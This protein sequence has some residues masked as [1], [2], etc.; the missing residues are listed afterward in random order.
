[1]KRLARSLLSLLLVFCLSAAAFPTP[2]EAG[3]YADAPYFSG[4]CGDNLTWVLDDDG[5][6]TISGTG[7]MTDY[8]NISSMPWYD[9]REDIKSVIIGDGVTSVGNYA[10]PHHYSLT[11]VTIPDSVT[12]IGS[13]AFFNCSGL[14]AVDIPNSVTSI[15][16]SAF[17]YCPFTSIV[18][19]ESVTSMGSGVFSN[20]NNL[21]F[22]TIEDG[23][24]S[25]GEG[26]FKYCSKLSSITIPGS[27]T[28]IGDYAF[29]NCSSLTEVVFEGNA[30]SIDDSAFDD[31]T[32]TCHYPAD[33]DTWTAA[34]R[35]NYGGTLTWV[36]PG[37]YTVQGECGDDVIWTLDSDGPLTISGTG[38]MWSA[39]NFTGDFNAYRN[40]I[41]TV[42]IE[43][44]VTSIGTYAFSYCANL[45][46]V[47]IPDS[48]TSI[49][50]YAFDGCASL[51]SIDIPESVT[52]IGDSVFCDCTSLSSVSIPDSITNPGFRTFMNCTNLTSVT[53]PSSTTGI[54]EFA[55]F[56]TGLTSISIPE[57][58]TQIASGAFADCRQLS[59]IEL[60][61]S[62]TTIESSALSSCSSL[63][64]VDFPPNLTT[65]EYDLLSSSGITSITIPEKV[66]S[67]GTY[68]FAN[69]LALKE[70]KFR[71]NAPSIAEDAFYISTATCYYPADDESWTEDVRQ[72][73]G[74]TLTWETTESPD[75]IVASGECGD[76]VIWTL[77]SNG[78]LTVSGTGEMTNFTESSSAPWYDYRADIKTIIMEDGATSIGDYAFYECANLTS[79]TIPDSVTAIGNSAFKYCKTLSSVT[80]PDKIDTLENSAFAYTGLTSI[81]IPDGI[82]SIGA[83]FI[84]CKS[85]SSI[86]IPAS[87]THISGG[88]FDGCSSLTSIELPPNLTTIEDGLFNYSGITSI[89]IPEKVTSIDASAFY[90][91]QGL[92][93]IVIPESVTSIGQTAF[94][95]CKNLKTIEFTGNPPAINAYA[96][97][98]TTATCY[99][100]S[101]NASWTD[102]VKQ[103][104]G[105]TLTWKTAACPHSFT[106]AVGSLCSAATCTAPALHWVK[107]DLCG[108]DSDTLTVSVGGTADHSFTNKP[109]AE[110][111]EPATCF[112]PASYYV[113]CDNCT[114]V[115][116][117]V[118]VRSGEPNPH[119]FTTKAGTLISAAT[120]TEPALHRVQCDN[121]ETNST[122]ET[123]TV[124]EALGH[125]YTTKASAQLHTAG[126]CTAPALYY[127]Q[128]DR[129][130]SVSDTLT[131]A[132]GEPAGHSFVDYICTVCGTEDTTV[133][134]SGYCG[135]SSNYYSV[136]W[137][138]YTSGKLIISGSG[139]T[140][141]YEYDNTHYIPLVPWNAH[142]DKITSVVVKDGVTSVGDE[143]FSCLENLKSA[144]IAGSVRYL[145]I[146]AFNR[147]SQLTEVTLREGVQTLG[148]FLFQSCDALKTI[149]LP[150][151]LTKV[152]TAFAHCAGLES[153]AVA[154]GSASFSSVDGVLFDKAQTC[155]YRYP[156]AR[157]GSSYQVPDTVTRIGQYAFLE[158]AGLKSVGLPAG[159]SYIG[160][161]AF[162]SSGLTGISI[163]DGVTFGG[164]VFYKCASLSE[165]SL[166]ADLKSIPYGLFRNCSALTSVTLPE[167][168]ETIGENA[169]ESSGL[170]GVIFPDS[171]KT[172]SD[173]AFAYSR[174]Q[175]VVIPESVTKIGDYAF[176]RS[177]SLNRLTVLNAS[178]TLGQN[179]FLDNY[180]E[181][182]GWAGST[183]ETYAAANGHAFTV[184]AVKEKVLQE[185][186]CGD[187]GVLFTGCTVCGVGEES[188]IPAT[189]E[190]N[191]EDGECTVCGDEIDGEIFGG[192][193]WYVSGDT[194]TVYAPAGSTGI[195]KE[196]SKYPWAGCREDITAIIVEEGVKNISEEAF[197]DFVNLEEVMLPVGLTEIEKNAFDG[198]EDADFTICDPDCEILGNGTTLGETGGWIFCHED[199]LAMEYA[200]EYDLR[201]CLSPAAVTIPGHKTEVTLEEANCIEGEHTLTRCVRDCGYQKKNY[202]GEAIPDAHRFDPERGLCSVCGYI[203]GDSPTVTTLSGKCGDNLYWTLDKSSMT[204]TITGT[205][206]MRNYDGGHFLCINQKGNVDERAGSDAP[207]NYYTPELTKLI[208][209]NGMTT[210]GDTA[211]C[212]AG[213]LTELMLPDSLTRI[214]SAAFFGI[215]DPENPANGLAIPEGV[216]YIGASAFAEAAFSGTLTI[217]GTLEELCVN[218]FNGCQFTHVKLAEGVRFL[219]EGSLSFCDAEGEDLTSI[220]V[221]LPLSLEAIDRW[222]IDG[223]ADDDALTLNYAGCE[224]LWQTLKANGCIDSR[225]NRVVLNCRPHS[226]TAYIPSTDGITETTVCDFGCGESHTRKI[227]PTDQITVAY[228]EDTGEVALVNVP[229]ELTVVLAAYQ[230]GQMVYHVLYSGKSIITHKLPDTLTADTLRLFF[231]TENRLPAGGQKTISLAP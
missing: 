19:P 86:D 90:G 110:V 149:T 96:F 160:E 41:K 18:I 140:G 13:C 204:L 31:V 29:S 139:Q 76:D 166:P 183:A 27:V 56:G 209:P 136:T 161:S 12:A 138:L 20:C 59:S 162:Q 14:S 157:S 16:D 83:A 61:D 198:C 197:A 180:G 118:S 94:G 9:Y 223:Y 44:G 128:C 116:P 214:G 120:C 70:I 164:S 224:G 48:V 45:T 53:L 181:L 78:T 156:A 46:T 127:V 199:S 193:A 85:L 111:A 148:H 176:S 147:C 51:L 225:M 43:E 92:T 125:S 32:A 6:L 15:G 69:C 226:F 107:C 170:T 55:F 63:T 81:V 230:D 201:C 169:F 22:V 152:D 60:P 65:I 113:Q 122:T 11:S 97:Q 130:E 211:F 129:C 68:A 62:V 100:P 163:P 151:S 196:P 84:G 47:T 105:G 134:A 66:T 210:I 222:A 190:H 153:I 38:P 79:V 7:T 203:E 108:E 135:G 109:S 95:I 115:T 215:G 185:P 218:A 194:L 178:C 28:S 82:A 117:T 131:V 200:E 30:P 186:T 154:E 33:H 202:K 1:M 207:W 188:K 91:C 121:C 189:G 142:L 58:V 216:T 50:D 93:S 137:T 64:S 21:T 4:T 171:L 195:M 208:L 73:Y 133:Y 49:G 227:D 39:F 5:I 88:A 213:K 205:G 187:T 126:T 231:L 141:T 167:T 99:Y 103:N 40:N 228:D 104:Y 102:S 168:L 34:V 158:T 132:V 72:N 145:G 2:A 192:V 101:N 75:T 177:Y 77:D 114:A 173:W 52:S 229:K 26:D 220:T 89:T 80:L 174:L 191:Y 87:V 3:D 217:P 25:I 155:L 123:V 57:G 124:G 119:S 212:Y 159:L 165:V 71:G 150:A 54:G 206:S 219:R 146:N 67:I 179:F 106:T 37:Q 175:E 172:I 42:T 182:H 221:D 143:M 98:Q 17:T 10:F 23:V 184:H 24:T 8:S 36:R 112:T 35:Q 144:D 74:G